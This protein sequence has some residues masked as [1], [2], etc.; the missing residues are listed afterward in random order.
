[1]RGGNT[2][3]RIEAIKQ[4][5]KDNTSFDE[6]HENSL[7]E[8]ITAMEEAEEKGGMVPGLSKADYT[9]TVLLIL[10]LGLGPV[11]YYAMNLL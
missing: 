10:V 2:L 6:K 11:A 5:L 3:K 1:M 4:E 9:T 7:F 8:A